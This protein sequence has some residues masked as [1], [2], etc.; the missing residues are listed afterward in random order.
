MSQKEEVNESKPID[1]EYYKWSKQINESKKVDS[2]SL[3]L[4]D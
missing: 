3:L 2:W 1:S 4:C